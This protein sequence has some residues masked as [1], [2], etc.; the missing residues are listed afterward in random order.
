MQNI[1]ITGV[2]SGLGEALTELYLKNGDSVYAIG[3]SIPKQFERYHNFFFFPYDLSETFM[4]GVSVKE[5]IAHHSFDV[6]ILNAGILGDMGSLSMTNTGDI[7]EVMEINTWSN[8]ELID[9][10]LEYAHAKQ[11]VAISSNAGNT[12]FQGLGAYSLSKAAL[13]MLISVYAKELP[14]MHFTSISPG[15]MST[16]MMENINSAA[17]F[18]SIS[19]SQKL[20]EGI[21]HTPEETAKLLVNA[22]PELRAQESGSFIDLMT[23]DY[24]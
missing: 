11:V 17:N 22:L 21:M 1:L 6:V 19:S 15:L 8:K 23:M 5:F 18:G 3:K 9:A 10:I 24:Y 4:L 12:G 13:N 16:K 2:S 20:E 7:K 14:D